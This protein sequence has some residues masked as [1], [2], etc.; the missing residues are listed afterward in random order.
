M[1]RNKPAKELSGNNAYFNSA[2]ALLSLAIAALS[3]TGLALT[4]H[5]YIPK[6]ES[7]RALPNQVKADHLL[8]HPIK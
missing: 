4:L 1:L 3:I 7:D 5:N 2:N 8:I 6:L